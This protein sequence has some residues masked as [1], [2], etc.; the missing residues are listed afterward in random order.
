MSFKIRNHYI[1][2]NLTIVVHSAKDCCASSMK[3]WVSEKVVLIIVLPWHYINYRDNYVY[4]CICI[5]NYRFIQPIYGHCSH[6][7]HLRKTEITPLIS[8]DSQ[9]LWDGSIC[10]KWFN[11]WQGS[12]NVGVYLVDVFEQCKHNFRFPEDLVWIFLGH[13]L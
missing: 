6:Y 5:F 10:Q 2:A 7:I 3:L 13:V 1:V 9:R 4:I 8:W 11:H 12:W